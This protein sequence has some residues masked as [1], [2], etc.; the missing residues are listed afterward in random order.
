M[1]RSGPGRF[2]QGGGRWIGNSLE[3]GNLSGAELDVAALAGAH[4]EADHG[5]ELGVMIA[6]HIETVGERDALGGEGRMC[7][8]GC[9]G[10]DEAGGAILTRVPVVILTL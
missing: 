5:A 7:D 2:G 1:C 6:A 4:V 9:G 3:A 10:D 8:G